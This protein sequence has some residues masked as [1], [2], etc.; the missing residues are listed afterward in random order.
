MIG[1]EEIVGDL[2]ALRAV[3]WETTEDMVSYSASNASAYLPQQVDFQP[4]PGVVSAERA[5]TIGHLM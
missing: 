3:R 4:A 2:S 5:E 1:S